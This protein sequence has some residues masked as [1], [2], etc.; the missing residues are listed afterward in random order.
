MSERMTDEEF[1]RLV[2]RGMQD[3]AGIWD[4]LTEA[5]RARAAEADL[6]AALRLARKDLEEEGKWTLLH[7]TGQRRAEALLKRLEWTTDNRQCQVC[8]RWQYSGH[9]EDCELAV[10]LKEA[11][12]E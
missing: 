3:D 4:A 9:T 11:L 1:E 8:R 10:A 12:G 6:E 5:R 2:R 7:E